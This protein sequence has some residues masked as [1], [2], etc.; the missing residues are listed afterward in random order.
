MPSAPTAEEDTNVRVAARVRPLL[1]REMAANCCSCVTVHPGVN[2]LV[3]GTKRAF[4]FDMVFDTD[5]QQSVV[6]DSCVSPLLDGCMQGYNATVLA[7]GQTGSGKTHTMGTGQAL[8]EATEDEGITP[9]VIRNSFEYIEANRHKVDFKVSCCYLEI[10]N[11][12]LRDLLQPGGAKSLIAVRE[13]AT[14]GIKVSGI[15]A[16]TCTSAEE[17]MR[18][19]NDGSVQR[20][21]GATLMNEQSSRSHSIFT[22]ILEQRRVVGVSDKSEVADEADYVTAKFHLVDLAG[23]E[24]AKRTGAVGSRFKESVSINS[25]LLALGNVISALGD[26]TKR[27]SHVPYRESKLTRLLQDSLGGNSRTV[28]VACVSCADGDFEETLNTLKYAHRARNIKNKPVVNHDPR[29]AQLAA[30]QDEIEALRSQLQ[31][32]HDSG[33]GI[34]SPSGVPLPTNEEIV[35]LTAKLETSEN[36]SS[37]LAERL[38]GTET[39]IE[40]LRRCLADIDTAVCQHLPAI[41]QAPGSGEQASM[42]SGRQALTAVCEVLQA[43]RRLL[44]TGAEVQ[45]ALDGTA[46]GLTGLACGESASEERVQGLPPLPLHLAG[47]STTSPE[48]PPELTSGGDA[49]ASGAPTPASETGR[50]Q[51]LSEMRRDS[52]KLIRK[53]LDDINRLETEL[54]LYRRRTNQLQ[55][56]LREARDDLQKDE[57]IFEEK[58]REM[59]EL[60]ERNQYLEALQ[61][62]MEMESQS[63]RL[64]RATGSVKDAHLSLELADADELSAATPPA[65]D[66]RETLPK[67]EDCRLTEE[68]EGET[69][70]RMEQLEDG[71]PAQQPLEEQLH[72][73]AQNVVLKEDLIEELMRSEREWGEA[74]AQYQARMEQLQ[75][76]LEET[77]QQLDNVK[78]K[79]HQSEALEEQARQASEEEKRRLENKFNAQIEALRRKQQEFERLKDLRQS[80]RRRLKDLE[81]E[82]TQLRSKKAEVDKKLQ[83]ERKRETQQIVDLQRRLAREGQKVKDLEANLRLTNSTKHAGEKHRRESLSRKNSGTSLDKPSGGRGYPSNSSAADGCNGRLGANGGASSSSSS[84]RWQRLE[85]RLDEHI[86]IAEVSQGLEEDLRKQENL[87]KKREQYMSFRQKIAAKDLSEQQEASERLAR[88][89]AEITR[90]EREFQEGG[91][92]DSTARNRAEHRRLALTEEYAELQRSVGKKRVEGLGI[93]HDIDEKLESLQDELDFRE[94][95]ISKAQMFLGNAAAT[96]PGS[97]DAE[98]ACLPAED[99][100]ELLRRYCEKL[101]KLRQRE[102][103]HWQRIA[104]SEAQLQERNQ[105]VAEL[106]QVL[107]RQDSNSTKAIAKVTKEYESRI[108]QLLRQLSVSQQHG[109]GGSEHAGDVPSAAEAHA[110]D[111]DEVEQLRRDNQYYKAMNRELKRRLRGLLDQRGEVADSQVST[112]ARTQASEDPRTSHSRDS[113]H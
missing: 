7:Y 67:Q 110:L 77:Q 54:A 58:M 78:V 9:K 42:A 109:D 39:E 94:A 96:G 92:M 69:T 108:R 16:E 22:V 25:G 86:R 70:P 79:L 107:R 62:E 38:A 113:G 4:T 20:T 45:N 50:L 76:E 101:V 81:V 60:T 102:K 1:P 93:L 49:P 35:E 100:K 43:T 41:W 24:R 72:A 23:S 53:Y 65:S 46:L 37:E 36:R 66:E 95:R 33:G 55:E 47:L 32:V 68:P 85:Q 17:M 15:R 87:L 90:H 51:S 80:E 57:E 31:R 21:T 59:K 75:A 40:A 83:A 27:G 111:P 105:Q 88:L 99:G 3:V 89:E 34:A 97:L 64:T 56:E 103:Q 14:G 28:M 6:Y 10:Y 19:L 11:E 26:P 2:Q 12:D 61:L 18:C 29:T 30:M 106:E 52:K 71:K 112:G 74:K 13:D 5:V 8:P 91:S 63:P 44:G 73:L 84:T 82:V 104:A 48:L 98:L